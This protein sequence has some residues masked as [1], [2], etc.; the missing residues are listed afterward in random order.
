[1]TKSKNGITP[2]QRKE[3]QARHEEEARHV[4]AAGGWDKMIADQRD[5]EERERIA[6]QWS[7]ERGYEV[8]PDNVTRRRFDSLAACLAYARGMPGGTLGWWAR[9]FA[10][11]KAVEQGFEEVDPG[12]EH[13]FS[14]ALIAAARA[15]Q[16]VMR[17]PRAD[18]AVPVTPEATDA[19]LLGNA[20]AVTTADI[21]AYAKRHAPKLLSN[22]LL[23]S[24]SP[25]A[26]QSDSLAG[27]QSITP[28]SKALVAKAQEFAD[29]SASRQAAQGAQEIS[30]R[31]VARDV[32]DAL[33]ALG[34]QNLLGGPVSE[35]SV[36]T[37]LLKGWSYKPGRAR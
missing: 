17:Y 27:R 24:D 30:A 20:F 32:A 35:S 21:R 28:P 22:A 2:Q 29:S 12:T 34:V 25:Q 8:K 10:E 3:L 5:R 14:K 6:A 31:A 15:G 7:A 1:M 37:R 19:H 26:E 36:R 4:E 16:L 13:E 9:S 11:A 18:M 23:K 33:E